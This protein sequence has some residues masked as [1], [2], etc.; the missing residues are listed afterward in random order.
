MTGAINVD[1]VSLGLKDRVIIYRQ[2]GVV[3]AYAIASAAGY[4]EKYRSSNCNC[5]FDANVMRRMTREDYSLMPKAD[6]DD[7]MELWVKGLIFGLIKNEDGTYYY[8]N[9]A[10]GDILDDYW[11]ELASF[12]DEAYEMFRRK[13]GVIHDEYLKYFEK[14]ENEKGT[15]YLL[16]VIN[17][18]Q[19]DYFEKYS[20]LGM[21][22]DKLKERGNLAI[23]ELIKKE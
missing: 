3:P 22:K 5:H 7:T 4:E 13:K 20:Q 16:N 18:V 21:S 8:H 23:A 1:F 17:D 19:D 6:V 2:V 9:E 10:E 11:V 12:R 14:L 15:E